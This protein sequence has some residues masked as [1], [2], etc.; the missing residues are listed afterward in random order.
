MASWLRQA[1]AGVYEITDDTS[2][3]LDWAEARV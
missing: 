1:C 3:T 2:E